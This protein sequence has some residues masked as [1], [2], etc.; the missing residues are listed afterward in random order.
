MTFYPHEKP[1]GPADLPSVDLDQLDADRT[2]VHRSYE[3]FL[4]A[5]LDR[6]ECGRP[7]RW[8][9]DYT[10]PVRYTAS[11]EP[12]RRRLQEMLGFW[13]PPAQ[14]P[15]LLPREVE[16]F[17]ADERFT[18]RRFWFDILPGL[19]TYAVE[20]VPRGA[21]ASN[22]R[23]LLLQHGY[24]GAPECILGFVPGANDEDY[25]YRS[26]GLRAV[27]RGYHVLAVQHPNGYGR[28]EVNVGTLPG[29]PEHR[30]YGKN[31][32]HRL[33]SLGGA[34]LFGLDMMGSSRGLDHLAN[35]AGLDPQRLGLYGLS[36][37]GQSALFLPALD[38]RVRA[39]V[40]SAFFN[41]R[42]RKLIGPHRATSFLDSHEEDKFFP[43]VIS[44][45]SDADLVSLIAPRFFAVEAGTGDTSVDFEKSEA[46]FARARVHF[47]RLG[48][49]DHL[50]WIPHQGG[51]VSATGQ[52]FTFLERALR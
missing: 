22:G 47:D 38:E 11:I 32:L 31:R 49:A 26:L 9:R 4:R 16:E 7:D 33:A 23:G 39:S 35:C 14:R 36:Q 6:L 37:G 27:L 2:R 8:Q 3:D 20:L 46:E 21:V 41:D 25:S 24:H 44:H 19:E 28:P 12:M 40:C 42:T 10:D 43:Q 13:V 5:W 48:L 45:F 15:R 52:A 34:A 1:A 51:H 17:H 29:F 18:A 50:A 30:N